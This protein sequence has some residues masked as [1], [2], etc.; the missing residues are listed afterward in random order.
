MPLFLILVLLAFAVFVLVLGFYA[1]RDLLAGGRRRE[2]HPQQ[3]GTAP[4]IQAVRTS[5]SSGFSRT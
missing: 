3:S 1:T 5:P 2:A 4:R